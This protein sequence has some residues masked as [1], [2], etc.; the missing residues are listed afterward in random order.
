M[1][2]PAGRA[3][4]RPPPRLPETRLDKRPLNCPANGPHVGPQRRTPPRPASAPRA[5][6]RP[7]STGTTRRRCAAQPAPSPASNLRP[8]PRVCAPGL[9]PADAAAALPPAAQTTWHSPQLVGPGL[10]A[11]GL[12]LL[13]TLSSR[14]ERSAPSPRSPAASNAEDPEREIPGPPARPARTPVH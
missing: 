10:G 2:P 4:P 5:P 12:E 3:H 11:E 1:P 7:F 13:A 9:S 6:G 8:D 14:P